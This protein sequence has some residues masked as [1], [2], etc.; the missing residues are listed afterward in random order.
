MRV[1]ANVFGLGGDK[2]RAAGMETIADFKEISVVGLWEVF[3]AVP[4]ARQVFRQLLEET[5]RRKPDAAILIDFPEFNLRLA[6][7]LK[8]RGVRVIYYVSPQV[9]AWRRGRLKM[10]GKVVDRMLVFFGFEVDFYRG[11]VD[12][13]HVGHPLIDEVP[14]L[15]HVWDDVEAGELP[16]RPQIALL[17]GSRT[18]EIERMLPLLTETA[19]Q[20]D[21]AVG[22]RF[23]IIRAPSV[24]EETIQ[25]ALD[26]GA[27]GIDARIISEDRFEAIAS[28]HLALCTSG[29]A[30]LEVGLI[31]TPMIVVY[32]VGAMTS[33]MGRLL[34]RVPH[35]SLVNL[36]LG[37]GVMTELV[38]GHAEPGQICR[39]AISLLADRSRIDACRAQLAGLRHLLGEGGASRRAAQAVAEFLHHGEGVT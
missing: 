18:S 20:L 33:L 5:D 23:V 32:R 39:E 31:G 12:V 30:T 6:R 1:A 36:V 26:R 21:E 14:S 27:P 8:K 24:R 25:E 16:P 38:Q 4:R 3:R 28:S 22:C 35:I 10:I 9:W 15:P 13:T 34:I 11:S 2:L 17:P 37:G 19:V 7:Q 29:T